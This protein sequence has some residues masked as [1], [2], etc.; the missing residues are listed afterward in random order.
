VV[1][2][3]PLI[4]EAV[5]QWI[6]SG[7]RG[8]PAAVLSALGPPAGLL[9]YLWYWQVKSGDWLAPIHQETGWQRQAMNPLVSL[10]HGSLDA[11]RFVGLYPGGY[12]ELDWLIVVPALV[13]AA[14]ALWRFRPAFGIYTWVSILVPLCLVFDG[15]PLMSDP[16]FLLPLF[17]LMWA[18]AVWAE[19]HPVRHEVYVAGSAALLGLMLLL[20]VNWYYVF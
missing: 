14:Y 9:L 2:A 18:A 11:Y 5:H 17:P 12:H 20:F 13:A 10:W 4:V 8:R 1:L 3:L 7:R 16:R 15:R 6:E 19:G